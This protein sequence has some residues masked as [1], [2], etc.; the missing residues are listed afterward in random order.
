MDKSVK[1]LAGI[2]G[3]EGET[4]NKKWME[5]I[6]ERLKYKSRQVEELQITEQELAKTIKQTTGQHQEQTGYQIFGEK[7]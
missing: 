1:L 6:K 2:W 4:P 5:K 7:H 3:Y